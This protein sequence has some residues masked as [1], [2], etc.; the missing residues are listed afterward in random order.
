MAAIMQNKANFRKARMN[1]NI[2]TI[3]DYV[4]FSSLGQRKNKPKQSQCQT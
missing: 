4:N 3:M 1:A 2:Y